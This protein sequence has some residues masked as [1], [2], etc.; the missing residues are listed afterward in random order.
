MTRPGQLRDSG[1]CARTPTGPVPWTASASRATSRPEWS[2]GSTRR[3]SSCSR[4]WWSSLHLG[5][6]A[7]SAVS[8]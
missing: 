5:R 2:G 3:P 1:S 7:P 4:R 8:R 6:R